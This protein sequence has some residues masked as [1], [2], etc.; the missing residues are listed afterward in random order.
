MSFRQTPRKRYGM[1]KEER[2]SRF[3]SH[4]SIE[5]SSDREFNLIAAIE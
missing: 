5:N 3:I 2:L 4:S 1:Q